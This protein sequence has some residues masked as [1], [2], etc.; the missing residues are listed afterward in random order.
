MM[1]PRCLGK[2]GQPKTTEVVIKR[3]TGGV[4]EQRRHDHEGNSIAERQTM[5]AAIGRKNLL[6]LLPH[7]VT[8]CHE[9]E[10]RFHVAQKGACGLE[11]MPI[12]KQRGRL[13]DDVPGAVQHRSGSGRFGHQPACS[14]MVGVS[15]IETGI[16]K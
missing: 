5:I 7:A 10:S 6:R 15:W 11:A 2:N 9:A 1:M 14:H 16:E 12:Q 4:V 8:V 13:A 3:E